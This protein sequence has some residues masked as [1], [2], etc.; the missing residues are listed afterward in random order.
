MSLAVDRLA[1][2]VNPAAGGGRAAEVWK[3]LLDGAPEFAG[4][5]LILAADRES[6]R[7]RLDEALAEVDAVVALGGDGTAHL[8]ANR[9]LEAG[10]G[11]RVALGLIPAG[12]GSDFARCLGLARRP[13]DC[14]RRIRAAAP[15]AIDILELRTDAGSRRFAVN[16]A[17][18]GVSG[19]VAERVNA[20]AGRGRLTYLLGTIRAL[21]SY[22]PVPCRVLVDGEELCDGGFFVVAVGN[23]RSL[24]RGM[25]LAPRASIDDGLADVVL[26]P[27]F[28][29]WKIPLRIP[30]IYTGRHLRW[31][32]VRLVRGTNVRLEPRGEMAPFD[33]DGETLASGPATVRVLPRAIRV[34]A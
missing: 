9:I 5:R 17:S 8:V 4:A 28:P 16:F 29:L 7:L 10:L 21:L 32:G 34:L 27:P 1:V 24:G 14:W 20:L 25:R 3:R 13:S 15:R 22:A 30:S 33:V 2:L 26:V 31:R 6:A 19:F 23:G 11:E 12:S 18:A